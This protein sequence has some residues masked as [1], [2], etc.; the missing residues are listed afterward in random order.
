MAEAVVSPDET[1]A[2]AEVPVA[3]VAVVPQPTEHAVAALHDDTHAFN[4]LDRSYGK[5]VAAGY[6]GGFLVIFVFL[7]VTLAVVGDIPT[8]AIVAS[9]IAVAFWMGILGGVVAVGKW[10]MKHEE[11]I[12]HA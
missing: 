4:E 10:A 8:P 7:V 12:H 6:A 5:A 11:E 3:S 2:V 1:L 9:G